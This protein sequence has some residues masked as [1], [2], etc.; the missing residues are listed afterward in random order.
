[1]I[2]VTELA[3]FLIKYKVDLKRVIGAVVADPKIEVVDNTLEDV[4]FTLNSKPTR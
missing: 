3:Y 2:C 4:R 1:M